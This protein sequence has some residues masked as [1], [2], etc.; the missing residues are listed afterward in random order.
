[1]WNETDKWNNWICSEE[2][3]H[4]SFQIIIIMSFPLFFLYI[5]KPIKKHFFFNSNQYFSST[6]IFLQQHFSSTNY[7][8]ICG[9]FV[10]R[11]VFV[12]HFK[13]Q[14]VWLQQIDTFFLPWT[15]TEKSRLWFCIFSFVGKHIL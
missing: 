8:V 4:S 14:F 12:V 11:D 3:C 1:M 13:F 6:K 9:V 10:T 15:P 7:C 2:F 5:F